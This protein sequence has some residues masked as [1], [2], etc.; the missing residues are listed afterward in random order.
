MLCADVGPVAS[1]KCDVRGCGPGCTQ[2]CCALMWLRLQA[3][4]LMWVRLQASVVMWVRL[5]ASVL[6]WVRLHASVLCAD[7]VQAS[8][9]MWVRLQAG[10]LCA[11]VGAIA[12]R[13]LLLLYYSRA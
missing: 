9:L 7:V 11:D 8:A 10:V 3:S 13:C 4:V 6:M 12:S 2:V 1:S 5:Q